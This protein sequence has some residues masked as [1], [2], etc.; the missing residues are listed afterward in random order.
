MKTWKVAAP[1]LVMLALSLAV[2]ILARQS[3]LKLP[4]NPGSPAL[5]DKLAASPAVD[6]K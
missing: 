1:G 3:Q 5:V 2:A 6:A 4:V